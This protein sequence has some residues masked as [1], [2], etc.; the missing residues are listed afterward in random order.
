MK[1]FLKIVLWLITLAI[2]SS[3]AAFFIIGYDGSMSRLISFLHEESRGGKI[4]TL[5]TV[6]KFFLLQI[7]L[8]T[9]TKHLKEEGS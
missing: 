4:L 3:V 1:L 6:N 2:V 7:I 8:L 5:V 9:R